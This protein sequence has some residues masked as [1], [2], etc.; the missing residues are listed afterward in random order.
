M[1][2]KIILWAMLSML[3]C[4]NSFAA[5]DY[6]VTLHDSTVDIR[7]NADAFNVHL[8]DPS[9]CKRRYYTIKDKD[10]NAAVNNITV[11]VVG[12]ANIDGGSTNTINRA[13]ES[14]T[15][16]STGAKYIVVSDYDPSLI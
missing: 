5:T 9:T 10:G 4:G 13:Y 16:Q 15:F 2:K 7:S 12:G 8:K 6:Y 3:L 1:K 14:R 11:D